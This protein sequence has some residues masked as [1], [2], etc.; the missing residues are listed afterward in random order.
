MTSSNQPQPALEPSPTGGEQEPGAD[1]D[2][3]DDDSDPGIRG[4]LSRRVC[5]AAGIPAPLLG[6]DGDRT[7]GA[8]TAQAT[9]W[10]SRG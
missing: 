3:A 5:R 8:A 7:G 10:Q 6:G 9:A 4:F 1:E 2:Q